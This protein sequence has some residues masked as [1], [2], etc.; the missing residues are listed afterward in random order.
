MEW[1]CFAA[2]TPFA[3]PNIPGVCGHLRALLLAMSGVS[4]GSSSSTG[5]GFPDGGMGGNGGS[6]VCTLNV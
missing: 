6:V 2:Q 1:E 5:T 4:G 3:I